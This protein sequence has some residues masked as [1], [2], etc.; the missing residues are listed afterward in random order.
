MAT[1]SPLHNA[2]RDGKTETV[3][4][5]ISA[6]ADLNIR[7]SL[8]GDTPHKAARNDDTEMMQGLITAGA[9]VNA[10]SIGRSESEDGFTPFTVRPRLVKPKRSVPPMPLAPT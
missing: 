8:F 6:G 3:K 1:S 4:A 10:K 9:D 2:A 7:E 5:L